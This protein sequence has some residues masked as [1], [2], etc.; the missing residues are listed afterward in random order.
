MGATTIWEKWNSLLPDGT[1]NPEGMNSYNHYA[2]GS[3]MEWVYRRVAGIQYASPGFRRVKIMPNAIRTLDSVHAEFES[4]NGK[5][6]AGY[7]KHGNS[8]RYFA[9][10]PEG[11]DA[12]VCLPGEQTVPVGH[13]KFVC[14]REISPE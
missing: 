10:I 12:E 8:I 11:I 14:E 7:E 4:V 9:E 6:V 1:P 2:Y 3:V 5:I 13:G